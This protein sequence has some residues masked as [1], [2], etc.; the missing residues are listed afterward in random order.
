[1]KAWKYSFILLLLIITACGQ[2]IEGNM[3]EEVQ[4]FNFTT[5]D[6]NQLSKE[7]LKGEWWVANT[8]F[9]SCE[10]VCPPMTRNMSILQDKLEKEELDVQLVSFSIDPE[11]DTPSKLKEYGGKFGAD[12]SNW[13]F[14]TGYDFQ[15]IKEF[16][17]KSFKSLVDEIPDSD[18]YMHGT[19]FFLVNPEGEAIKKYKGTSEEEM[20][21][22]VEDLKKVK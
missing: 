12:Y 14:L 2:K 9:T 17:I 11:T 6:Q 13:T 22:I 10:T 19:S 7:D 21:K 15:T 16:S 4:P 3:S 1:M 18:Q 8:I 20:Q 5:Q